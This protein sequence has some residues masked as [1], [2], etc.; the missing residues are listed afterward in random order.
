MYKNNR[1]ERI[2]KFKNDYRVIFISLL[3]A[4]YGIYLI[5]ST[6]LE[7]F[8]LHNSFRHFNRTISDIR[9]DLS[10]LLGISIIYLSTLLR[11]RKRTAWLVTLIANIFYFGLGLSQ[12]L[13]SDYYIFNTTYRWIFPVIKV[14]VL[15]IIILSLLYF[16]RDLFVVKSDVRGFGTSIKFIV[17]VIFVTLIYGTVGFML[18]DKADYH[19]E[20]SLPQ[21]IHYTVDQ[22]GITTHKAARAYTKKARLFDDSLSFISLA[23]LIYIL[24]SLFQPLRLRFADQTGARDK[25]ISILDRYGGDSEEFFK[26]WPH[27]KQY[28]FSESGQSVIAFH[29]Y[30]GVALV[31]GDPVGDSKEIREILNSFLYMCFSNDWSPSFIH[32]SNKY[33]EIYE[34]HGL[35]VQKLGE[36]AVVNI[37]SFQNLLKDEKYFRQILNKFTKHGYTFEIL[38]PPHHQAIL[39]R[40][41]GISKEWLSKGNR[42]ERGFALGY[43]S[44]EYMQLCDVAVARDAAG[45]I[46]GFLNIIPAP[47]D[48]QEVTYDM[49]RSSDEALGNIV[50]YLIINTMDELIIKG[51]S[52]FNMGLSPL[53]GLENEEDDLDQ[54]NTSNLVEGILKLVYQ[55]GGAFFSFS[56]LRKF[57]EKYQPDWQDKYVIYQGGISGFSKTMTMLTRFMTKSVKLSK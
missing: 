46:Q 45:T 33:L 44:D 50:D 28:F 13:N 22:F 16:Y 43:Y 47:W 38:S 3:V 5:A 56:G 52:R 11:S 17:I 15:P 23:S 29:V 2:V 35:T 20:I 8:F 36:E 54:T 26:I 12:L 7:Q 37:Q 49:I 1:A 27:D 34:E 42:S 10:L 4:F 14:I 39:S 24:F 48:R 57:K 25:V 32:T 30:H 55:R 53:S 18:M 40:F 6:L 51:Y 21:A 19:Q 31:V 9:V 41:N